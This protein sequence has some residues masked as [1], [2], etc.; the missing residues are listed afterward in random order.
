MCLQVIQTLIEIKQELN[1]NLHGIKFCLSIVLDL[2][3][4][5][6]G[7]QVANLNTFFF[8]FLI[9]FLEFKVCEESYIVTILLMLH[10]EENMK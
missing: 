6:L 3:K 2:Q 10:K 1:K 4:K 9:Y 8:L 5:I 7:I